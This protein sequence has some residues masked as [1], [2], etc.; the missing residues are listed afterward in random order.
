MYT[1]ME[2][3]PN[4]EYYNGYRGKG[5]GGRGYYRGR[6]RGRSYW[7]SRDASRVTC[8]RCDE[9]GHFAA[10]CPDRLLK[11][12]EAQEGKE[13]DTQEADKLM[14]HE[15][16]YLNERSVRPKEFESSMDGDKIWYLDNGASN[17][18]TG[19]KSYFNSM[20]ETVTGKVRFG[21]DSRIDIRGKG[22]ILFITQA[23][24]QKLL[25]DIY[26]LPNL[27]SNIISLGQ[28]TEA[29]CDV[30]IREDYLTLHDMDGNLIVKANRSRNRL[31]KVLMEIGDAK[32][33]KLE[34]Q[35]DSARWHA[36][37][38]HIG[39]DSM[40]LMIRKE[41]VHGIP[42]I[43]VERET[44]ESCL[45]GK[46]MRQVFPQ[47][48][49][50]RAAEPLE[51]I[52]GDL[53][54]PI[55]PATAAGN[56]YIFVL[57]DDHSRYMWT[58][59]LKNKGDA[60]DKFKIFKTMVEQE[61]KT[62]IKTLRTD[63]GDE[64]T[65]IEFQRF[66]EVSGIQRHLIA[67]Y[68]PQQNG[69]VERRNRTLMEMTRSIL[70]H[71]NIPN[72]L[73]GEAI[74]H[75]TYLINRVG[76]RTLDSQTPYE[77]FKKKKPSIKHLRVFRCI[78]YAKVD[79]PHLRKLD[80]RSRTLV[81]IGIEP[82]SKAY[83][84]LDPT[85]RKIIVSRDVVFDEHKTWKWNNSSEEV[86]EPGRFKISFGT[87]GNQ[88]ISDDGNKEET[89]DPDSVNNA[90]NSDVEELSSEEDI[91]T[92]DS[93]LRRSTR[94]SKPPG[95]LSDYICLA[96]AEG[97]RLLLLMNEEPWDFKDA[98]EEKV[99]KEACEDEIS[100]IIKN[101]TWELVDLPEGVKPIGLKWIFKI[102]RNSD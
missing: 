15:V 10:T 25:S 85:S 53:C 84:M 100:S 80:D 95:Y 81:H 83:R 1:N 33:L 69:I 90:I 64:F 37:L 98:I 71:M 21:D 5:R 102:K 28:A 16:V 67:P 34:V 42:K 43:E 9:I 23:G 30:R 79:A 45:R 8:F 7:D 41:L 73:W 57:V 24:E 17:H 36:R 101:K 26:F 39:V 32:C 35:S 72:Y 3:Q 70:K 47:A 68:I 66:F 49:S 46:Q 38:G 61:A 97:E 63:R 76:T 87:F 31:Y 58:I 40:K 29:G 44:C 50:Y 93:K 92:E 96:E 56:R 75:A 94:V 91:I 82:G 77:A 74:R 14:M 11:L 27:R 54:G 20:D 78:G 60:F 6:G 12:S 89:E 2:S 59:L 4:Q 65:S 62:S 88:G 55:T 86:K 48:T 51:L 13:D 18:M 99:W 19:N 52:H 22:S